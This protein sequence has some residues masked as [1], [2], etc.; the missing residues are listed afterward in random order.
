M[1]DGATGSSGL[2]S[3]RCFER[4]QHY[5][6]STPL[7]PLTT[8]ADDQTTP[9]PEVDDRFIALARL[10]LDRERLVFDREEAA[11]R[12]ATA[13]E[14]RQAASE[15][16]KAAQRDRT[17]SNRV[18]CASLALM[19]KQNRDE[20]SDRRESEGESA[21]RK[22]S[23]V[24]FDA[25]TN[26]VL[27]VIRAANDGKTCLSVGYTAAQAYRFMLRLTFTPP[28]EN[29][30]YQ[31][32]LAMPGSVEK[33][34]FVSVLSQRILLLSAAGRFGGT[35]GS[36]HLVAEDFVTMLEPHQFYTL[37]QL[38]A[39]KRCPENPKELDL[40]PD[41]W[42]RREQQKAFMFCVAVSDAETS[43]LMASL[44]ALHARLRPSASSP[45]RITLE[46]ARRVMNGLYM[47][48]EADARAA[49]LTLDI[50]APGPVDVEELTRQVKS[51]QGVV[52]RRPDIKPGGHSED[53]LTKEVA[54][55]ES[56]MRESVLR[57]TEADRKMNSGPSQKSKGDEDKKRVGGMT[58]TARR[59]SPA[60]PLSINPTLDELATAQILSTGRLTKNE[61]CA[62]DLFAPSESDGQ[63]GCYR[64]ASHS[65]VTCP[66]SNP[67]LVHGARAIRLFETVPH[68]AVRLALASYGGHV[69]EAKLD[70]LEERKS[71]MTEI[72]LETCWSEPGADATTDTRRASGNRLAAL[73]TP[74]YAAE[75]F[76][77]DH[78]GQ[79]RDL[80]GPK[81]VDWLGGRRAL[82]E[83]R[84]DQLQATPRTDLREMIEAVVMSSEEGLRVFAWLQ[85]RIDET[86]D[87]TPLNHAALRA[88]A[89]ALGYVLSHCT[90][91][92][93]HEAITFWLA[94]SI[95]TMATRCVD[96]ESKNLARRALAELYPAGLPLAPRGHYN[97]GGPSCQPPTP[98][99][100]CVPRASG[101]KVSWYD[102]R[103]SSTFAI[104]RFDTN[105]Q[106]FTPIE[107]RTPEGSWTGV[108]REEMFC[109]PA[110]G[111]VHA[112]ACA[113]ICLGTIVGATPSR[114]MAEGVACA[115][116]CIARLG[117]LKDLASITQFEADLR[118]TCHDFAHKN[119][120][121]SRLAFS[122]LRLPCVAGR[123][124]WT[125]E[126]CGGVIVRVSRV[127]HP[128][129]PPTT[130]APV[131]TSRPL[132]YGP[133]STSTATATCEVAA[134]H[135]VSRRNWTAEDLAEV[136]SSHAVSRRNWTAEDHARGHQARA[137]VTP[138]ALDV[139]LVAVLNFTKE[140]A[141]CY[142]LQPPE[143]LQTDAALRAWARRLEDAVT[144]EEF[145]VDWETALAAANATQ[146]RVDVDS[147]PPCEHCAAS[148]KQMRPRCS[149]RRVGRATSEA[150]RLASTLQD[151][152]RRFSSS[153]VLDALTQD[154][155]FRRAPLD[156]LP[157]AAGPADC[158]QDVNEPR[159][160]VAGRQKSKNV[161]PPKARLGSVDPASLQPP[162]LTAGQ[163]QVARDAV[164]AVDSA[165]EV[166]SAVWRAIIGC[167]FDALLRV[168]SAPGSLATG[169]ALRLAT[170][171]YRG[172]WYLSH[173]RSLDADRLEASK[174]L[175]TTEHFN[176]QA[177]AARGE[178]MGGGVS[179]ASSAPPSASLNRQPS[180]QL[181]AL[182]PATW[183]SIWKKV[184]TG[185]ALLFSTALATLLLVPIINAPQ[186]AVPKHD[187]L[188]VVREGVYRI[189]AN[190]SAPGA[191]NSTTSRYHH[192]RP[193]C[194]TSQ[195]LTRQTLRWALLY[196]GVD[197]IGLK[198]DVEAAYNI[199]DV[200]AADV[201]L[202]GA[203][204]P[205]E[206]DPKRPWQAVSLTLDFGFNGASGAYFGAV[207]CGIDTW[208][209]SHRPIDARFNGPEA[210]NSWTY[211]DD[212]LVVEP[213]LGHRFGI[214]DC[215]MRVGL[216]VHAG[217]NALN[218]VKLAEDGQPRSVVTGVGLTRDLIS[219]QVSVSPARV[220]KALLRW[221]NPEYH[222]GNRKITLRDFQRAVGSLRHI[223]QVRRSVHAAYC[224][225]NRFLAASDTEPLFAEPRGTPEEIDWMYHQ[226]WRWV[227]VIVLDLENP[228]LW[229]TG[230]TAASVNSLSLAER[231]A[232]PDFARTVFVL[233]GD[234]NM[235]VLFTIDPQHNKCSFVFW[236][237]AVQEGIL[238]AL[239]ELGMPL[240]V[241][242]E[243]MISLK[244]MAGPTLGIIRWGRFHG[245]VTA[246]AINDNLN[247]CSWIQTR[248]SSNPVAQHLIM[249]LSRAET[250]HQQDVFSA[251]VN[252][253]RNT[254]ADDG[255][256]VLLVNSGEEA[257]AR[258]A[259]YL[260]W[261]EQALPGYTVENWTSSAVEL[262][263]RAVSLGSLRLLSEP[264]QSRTIL[265][266]ARVP[267][268]SRQRMTPARKVG[269][270]RP[271]RENRP[272][273]RL[274]PDFGPASRQVGDFATN[275]SEA[276]QSEN[277]ALSD[278][279]LDMASVVDNLILVE[280]RER[281]EAS[282]R[283]AATPERRPN[284]TP[285]RL[286][287]ALAKRLVGETSGRAR[288][289]AEP[290][291]GGGG[292]RNTTANGGRQ[293][294]RAVNETWNSETNAQLDRLGLQLVFGTI[295][296]ETRTRYEAH[297]R[298]W[299]LFCERREP[300]GRGKHGPWL[301]GTEVER[302]EKHVID[303]IAYEGLVANGG[304]GWTVG[305]VRNKCIAVGFFHV[306]NYLTN[307]IAGNPRIK[308]ALRA[309]AR[310]RREPTAVKLPV[311]RDHLDAIHAR[312]SGRRGRSA[313]RSARDNATVGAA[314]DTAWL[315]L[316]RSSEYS[317]CDGAVKDYCLRLGDVAFYDDQQ[318]Q[319]DFDDLEAADSMSI[320][321]RGS[322]TD[323]ARTGCVR[324]LRRTG[325][326]VDAVGSVVAML[327]LRSKEELRDPELPLFM[328]DSGKA[329]S[330][331]HINDELKD[332]AEE[333]G[334]ERGRYATH[335]LRRGGATA[336]AA[337]GIPSEVIRR[338]GRWVSDTW[339]RYVFG[340]SEELGDL[341]RDMV[342]ARY[343]LA[344]VIE[345]FRATVPRA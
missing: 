208:H 21:L 49:L 212:S 100:L 125:I 120:D 221:K 65:A 238:S 339:R 291:L 222:Y 174:G 345:D 22:T 25:E 66:R 271:R 195:Q 243:M 290:G 6:A 246:L 256:R 211:G 214:S 315:F 262:L 179:A 263:G 128:P 85:E 321:I 177:T 295:A 56:R 158:A 344:M 168:C 91:T 72:R 247:A 70:T 160:R 20:T 178:C 292:G 264:W 46:T 151:P 200:D 213:D 30:L 132:G 261:A 203:L 26:H 245:E 79:I 341:A 207:A 322:K 80:M 9:E 338:W 190:H 265:E 336:M 275:R 310:L 39:L 110:T 327:K 180:A 332:A 138:T 156:L 188:G 282:R 2:N 301:N 75:N 23:G 249:M 44:E 276:A 171:A 3:A 307:P 54:A 114:V 69:T 105:A 241:S 99:G 12:A 116:S 130:D 209:N 308:G 304:K 47:R 258:E 254:M 252:T 163:M 86:S 19:T 313:K 4:R 87:G 187:A 106:G 297:F 64:C 159:Q 24:A 288:A 201:R 175:T 231:L 58:E 11:A 89:H 191:V 255:T 331:A 340:T 103:D 223:A 183:A 83:R 305:T 319:L 226:L 82:Q 293:R 189:C 248:T 76:D 269:S 296:P 257:A 144:V 303:F 300:A 67:R 112:R 90:A 166:Y 235:H 184:K 117:P 5:G 328:M 50:Y 333:L 253:K 170:L 107:V 329:I 129:L 309:L 98:P 244:E 272:P 141:H 142:A 109:N 60:V 164:T 343:T 146:V 77:H 108:D 62:A 196:P 33:F 205:D 28:I 74:L 323:Q 268:D 136:A 154:D 152:L 236:T 96:D 36:L 225:F 113:I 161:E 51:L 228:E 204:I 193:H 176:Y 206:L 185:R 266:D 199:V 122:M 198:H 194:P 123:T 34:E 111:E 286:A 42:R 325:A 232:L 267:D 95:H 182:G 118:E 15:E 326:T 240:D 181:N 342:T 17:E 284:S 197:Q 224:A 302:D 172:A 273:N 147:L 115:A 126:V 220:A 135:A 48:L 337:A 242:Q 140:V 150:L 78:E 131:E 68:P 289:E 93:S 259:E 217:P 97:D 148:G 192:P 41:E 8:A 277:A 230:V 127:Y 233:A 250:A 202:F 311:T 35:P 71:R 73:F 57:L 45:D 298:H 324:R 81:D 274:V 84:W 234:S 155:A 299:E 281:D 134:S 237:R 186:L 102:E 173:P 27:T 287:V 162:D 239:A 227:E 316:L 7:T 210:F 312:V 31:L 157:E 251:Y 10:Q 153:Q 334:L 121:F 139:P 16:R 145:T 270:S 167:R 229:V 55:V 219:G 13:A 165:D 317:S 124:L 37:Q 218:P 143:A 94:R 52:I 335:S 216:F 320:A 260:A 283:A 92:L 59:S 40:S 18:A 88:H 285:T 278:D 318:R 63:Q 104:T 294:P 119:H 43:F 169:T 330:N 101:R 279:V 133:T 306:A 314:L 61:R 38:G 53:I 14:E 1:K 149:T 280:Q 137:G 215:A 29:P 32:A